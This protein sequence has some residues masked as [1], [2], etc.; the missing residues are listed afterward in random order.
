MLW[1]NKG[2]PG[3]PR[4][5]TF[6]DVT[7]NERKAPSWVAPAPPS[8]PRPEAPVPPPPRVPT[9]THSIEPPSKPVVLSSPPHTSLLALEMAPPLESLRVPSA[10]SE[11]PG[12]PPELVAAFGTALEE[13]AA[14]RAR[15]LFET[16]EQLAELAGL[17]AR[18]VIARELALD[19]RLVVGLVQEGLEAL[20]AYDQVTVRLGA[21]FESARDDLSARLRS[22][23]IALEIVLD[24]T[25]PPD[26]CVVETELGRVD[27]SLETRLDH[28]LR[29][30]ASEEPPSR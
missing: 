15:L 2:R 27:E 3:R 24:P 19:P 1:S 5:A 17:I 25:L 18:R 21:W 20:G 6:N 29:G 11:P 10:P 14:A 26:G 9:G 23:G 22:R 30:L 4:P 7:P 12:P 8:L 13:L 16:R 28:L